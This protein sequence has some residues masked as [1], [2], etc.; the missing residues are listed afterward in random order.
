MQKTIDIKVKPEPTEEEKSLVTR[1]VPPHK[2]VSRDVTEA[3]IERI[4]TESVVLWKLCF[5]PVGLYAAAF[6]MAHPQIDDKD[7][8]RMFVTAERKIILNPVITQH[9]G[10]TVDSKEGCMSMADKP[11]IIV[12]RWRKCE[13]EY[14]TII[15]DPTEGIT[16]HPET[17]KLKLSE[18]IKESLVGRE[19]FCFQHEIGHL[20]GKYIYDELITNEK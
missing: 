8:L 18:I 10:Y 7:P 9:S 17:Y 5:T 14:I 11:L 13:V 20:N 3:D 2:K 15:R 6:A 1:L 12:P 4:Q 19:S 16:G